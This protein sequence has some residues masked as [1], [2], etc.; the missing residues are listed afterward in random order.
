MREDVI[1][2]TR[3][4]VTLLDSF[5]N[6]AHVAGE[7]G[8][9]Q[10]AG[11]AV[12]DFI[13]LIG[14][15]A[16]VPNQ[17]DQNA[18]IDVARA[19]SHHDA[20]QRSESHAGVYA[21]AVRDRGNGRAV[22]KMADDEPRRIRSNVQQLGGAPRGVLHADAVESIAPD[23]ALEPGIRTGINVGWRLQRGVES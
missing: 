17:I 1:G 22:A 4:L 6:F 18:G 15:T 8:N 3:A 5:Q 19:R 23:S 11:F 13:D 10:E 2:Q 7:S 20:F 12:Q 16:L 21:L 14:R 9:T